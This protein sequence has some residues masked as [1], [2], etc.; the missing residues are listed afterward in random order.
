MNSNTTYKG[1]SKK[2]KGNGNT[3][4]GKDSKRRNTN[5]TG[6]NG[7]NG[8]KLE[9]CV[10][11]T[12]GVSGW[13]IEPLVVRERVV[14]QVTYVASLDGGGWLPTPLNA[15]LVMERLSCLTCL[16]ALAAQT[17]DTD[18]WGAEMDLARR[19]GDL[20][21]PG[22]EAFWTNENVINAS[23][24]NDESSDGGDVSDGGG[25]GGEEKKVL[26]GTTMKQMPFDSK[27]SNGWA[28][29]Q[30]DEMIVRGV[31]Y[32][33]SS[34]PGYKSK[35]QSTPAMYECHVSVIW[36]EKKIKVVVRNWKL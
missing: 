13:I 4:N 24:T 18:S 12:F 7:D 34:H 23:G 29:H 33:D 30:V 11:G 2:S 26:T 25:G 17:L 21:E 31:G 22:A 36:K 5:V 28:N 14:S 8:T 6:N 35:V 9:D 16:K 15:S 27:E 32:L 20:W 19:P 1:G 10:V 3:A